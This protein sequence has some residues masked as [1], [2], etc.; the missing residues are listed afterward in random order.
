MKAVVFDMDGTILDTLGDLRSSVNHA[1]REYGLPE[2]SSAE[3][4]LF[5]GSGM[6]YLIHKAV[7]EGTDPET[8]A[9]V[10]A[11]H[12]TYYPMHCAEQ[13]KPYPGICELLSS[14]RDAG[15]LTAVVSNKSDP[16]VQALVKDY[17]DGLFTVAVG[18]RDGIPRKPSPELVEIALSELGVSKSDAVYI[19][20]SDIDVATARNAGL[21]MITVLWGFRDK[22]QLI[23]AGAERFA[24]NTD[25]VRRMLG[26]G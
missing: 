9:S 17:F 20:D 6:V 25:D 22:P 23:E 2:R 14:L 24:E 19:G 5:L 11:S 4:R 10:L 21:S 16:N 13:T 8:E 15:I 12:K 1:L 7:P 3:I 26:V 18:A